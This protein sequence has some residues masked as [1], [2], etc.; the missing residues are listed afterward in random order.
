MNQQEFSLVPLREQSTGFSFQSMGQKLPMP[1]R[2]QHPAHAATAQFFSLAD[3]AYQSQGTNGPAS[4]GK[5]AWER[6]SSVG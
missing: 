2:V 4:H 6:I 1:T 5:E 3:S